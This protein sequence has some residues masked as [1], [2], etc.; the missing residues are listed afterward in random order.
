MWK[1]PPRRQDHLG[2]QSRESEIEDEECAIFIRQVVRGLSP[3]LTLNRNCARHT[4]VQTP[5]D[6]PVFFFSVLRYSWLEAVIPCCFDEYPTRV[7]VSGFGYCSEF[8]SL[9]VGVL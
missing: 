9:S 4:I 8:A 5:E 3:A 1:T 6:C 7:V 2:N